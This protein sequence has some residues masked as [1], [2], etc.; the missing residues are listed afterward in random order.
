MLSIKERICVDL[1]VP[2]ELVENAL[3]M[4]YIRYRK[5]RVPKR[6]GG[7]RTIVQPAAELKLIQS[8]LLANVFS[9]LPVSEIAT[10]F[11]P[12]RS[13]V[14]NACAHKNAAYTV[15]TDVADFFP[16]IA[17]T[18]L[19]RVLSLASSRLPAWAT[20]PDCIQLITKACFDRNGRLPIGYP[21]S[22]KIANVVMFNFDEQLTH[23]ISSDKDRFGHGA[24]VTRYADDFV[25]STSRRG[26]CREFVTAIR[27]LMLSI[28][29]PQ[30]RFNEGKTRFMSRARGSTLV[31]G[32]RINSQGVVGVHPNYRDHVRLLIKL[33]AQ[34][35]LNLDDVQK[36]RGHL[37]FIEHAD[38]RLFTRLSFRYFDKITQL[39]A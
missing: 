32:L 36:L 8:W 7:Y 3:K 21:S 31:T 10:A 24:T 23:I 37:A 17:I 11:E 27:D 14:K 30:L 16:S 19:Q 20:D 5:I 22:P 12:G 25:F 34:G 18:D 35:K 33:Y 1:T 39:R 28:D 6:S 15:R 2:A 29:F 38:P 13:I 26:A 4:A 9:K